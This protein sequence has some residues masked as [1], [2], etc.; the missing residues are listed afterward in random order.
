MA[1][2]LRI[3]AWNANGLGN[4]C[5]EVKSFLINQN[6]DILLVSETH[7]TAKSFMKIPRYN[8]YNTNHPDGTGHGGTAIIIKNT[9]K[10]HEAQGYRHEHIQATNIVVQEINRNITI[11]SVYCPPKYKLKKQQLADYFDILGHRFISAGDFNAKNKH[12]GSRLDT[13]R[14][15]ELLKAMHSNGL[16][17]LSTGE[18]THWPSDR[19]KLPDVID[20]C[21]TKGIANNKMKIESC[22]DLAYDHSPIIITYS[23]TIIKTEKPQT[24]YNKKTNWET[25]RI[26]IN[27]RIDSNIS[28]KSEDELNKAVSDFNNFLQQAVRDA[29]PLINNT[30][31][32][33][34]C[35]MVVKQKIREKRIL[36]KTWQRT[37][38]PEDKTNLNNANKQLKQL[39]N[40]IKNK[41]VQDYLKELTPTEATGYSLWKATKKLKRPQTP[42]PP[43][44]LP[45]GTWARTNETKADAFG[46]HFVKVFQP[47]PTTS[48]EQDTKIFE[49][50]DTPPSLLQP[51]KSIKLYEVK[52]IINSL[53]SKKA[54]GHDLITGII[55]KELPETGIRLINTLF[56]AI[57]RLGVFPKQWKIAQIVLIP[58]P[59]KSPEEVTSYRPISLLPI[60]SKLFEKLLLQKLTPILRAKKVIPDHQFGFQNQHATIEQ[61]HRVASKINSGLQTKKFCSAAFL[62]I[63]Q[64]FDKVWHPGLLFKLK[65]NLPA[66]MFQILR[67]YLENRRFQISYKETKT[68]LFPI[69]AGVPQG[70]VL[71]PTLYLIYTA[72]L[73][74]LSST[75]VATFA[76]DTAILA[77]HEDPNTASRILQTNLDLI[78][79][80]LTTWRIR[81]N[82]IKST[83]VT[84]TMK[85]GTCPPVTINNKQLPQAESV[86]YLGMHFDRR[87]TWQKHIWSKRKQMGLKVRQMYWM[88]GRNSQLT[89]ENKL[90]LYKIIIKPIWT[91]GSQL[92][93]A[94]SNSNI[95]IIERFQSKMLRMILNAP[96]Y[97][98]NWVILQDLRT[99]PV[100]E[101][102]KNNSDRYQ[103]RLEVHPNKLAVR[104]LN[105][106]KIK[107]LKRHDPLDLP[108]RFI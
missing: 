94:A 48:P 76:D 85:N 53:Q 32:I 33:E 77:T 65:K 37:R 46:R 40:E 73:P 22:L 49:F 88:I 59:G 2:F 75:T 39:L 104:L 41:S 106:C 90:L 52:D 103:Q 8:I 105:E 20:I 80:W 64:A 51:I 67:S 24:L 31:L 98:P 21:F 36:R 50:L 45:N 29:T 102:I 15:R 4:H 23:T 61:I 34:N 27:Q 6:I 84:F 9:V 78:Q 91:Y 11:S 54:P 56:N 93:G 18:P 26:L 12:W 97:V 79:D 72:D 62:D 16:N 92:W 44:K 25:F 1:H 89:V 57:L 107:R 47:F 74:T 28:L 3:A 69:E 58:K 10:H 42:I 99:A 100:K 5:Q 108:R 43:I 87:L 96:W 38:H 70:S 68:S 19:R 60:L 7:F 63:S 55:L 81:A 13:T 71:G 83:H 101:V 17:C 95:G 35:P 82:E 30:D 86:K 14:G 66:Q